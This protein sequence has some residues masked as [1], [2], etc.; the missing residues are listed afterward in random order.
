MGQEDDSVVTVFAVQAR[1][2]EFGSP[3]PIQTLDWL[4]DWPVS[5]SWEGTEGIP[6]ARWPCQGPPGLSERPCLNE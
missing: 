3:E 2:P 6:R 5:P 1:G 4:S